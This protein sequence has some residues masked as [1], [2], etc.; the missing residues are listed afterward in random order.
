MQNSN[1]Q[2]ITNNADNTLQLLNYQEEK[3]L[4]I[5]KILKIEKEEGKNKSK[6]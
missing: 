5:S 3:P 6:K 1:F 4:N 2:N